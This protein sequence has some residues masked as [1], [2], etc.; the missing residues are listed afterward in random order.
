M[1]LWPKKLAVPL[2]VLGEV[3]TRRGGSAGS[4]RET[5]LNESILGVHCPRRVFGYQEGV[6]QSSSRIKDAIDG[7]AINPR[8]PSSKQLDAGDAQDD[9]SEIRRLRIDN[10]RIAYLITEA[11][12][13][14]D[15][16]AVRKRP[17]YD[18]GDLAELLSR[19]T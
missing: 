14:V 19:G 6:W 15:V 4:R 5:S 1:L 18:Y 11:E 12:K 3:V 13:A 17:P 16:V 9:K 10:W 8:P 2:R 7:L